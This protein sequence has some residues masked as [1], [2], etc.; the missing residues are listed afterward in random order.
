M[1]RVATPFA[2]ALCLLCQTALRAEKPDAN[3]KGRFSCPVFA[4]ACEGMSFFRLH[5][6]DFQHLPALADSGAALRVLML[7]YNAYDSAYA[8]KVRRLIQSQLPACTVSE[9]WEGTA[10]ELSLAL[11]THHAVVITYPSGGDSEL[12]RTYGKLLAQFVRQGG[13]VI[14]TGTNDFQALQ[15]LGLFDVESG[16][17]CEDPVIHE[18]VSGHAI[19]D[20]TNSHIPLSDFVYPLEISDPDFVTLVDVLAYQSDDAPVSCWTQSEEEVDPAT[21]RNFPVIGYKSMGAGK[22]VY[23]G[24]EYYYDQAEP[25]RILAN[26]LRWATAPKA[27]DQ[28]ATSARGVSFSNKPVKRSAE[29]LQAGTGPKQDVFDLKIYPNPYFDK[30]TLDIELKKNTTLAVEMTDE[31]GRIV[32]VLLPQKNLGAGTYR[33]ELPNLSTGVYFVQCKT[34]EKVTTRKVVKTSTR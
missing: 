1:L 9:F 29:V 13:A 18:I 22:I 19:L 28:A 4:Q 32:A 11:A 10:R 14:L 5:P 25:A 15:H 6:A 33:L 23:L 17:Y 34:G 3:D 27:G 8:E 30:A 21:L 31:S 24:M 20:G 16:Y 12:V 26:T 2:L 7:D